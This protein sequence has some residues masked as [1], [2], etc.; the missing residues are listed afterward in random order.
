M[1]TLRSRQTSW[2]KKLV[3]AWKQMRGHR[4]LGKRNKETKL[5][6]VS[7]KV[8]KKERCPCPHREG[9]WVSR[10][11]AHSFLDSAIY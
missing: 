2:V 9:I 3:E 5:L 6:G 1:L 7:V 4:C 8:K 11:I 10:G